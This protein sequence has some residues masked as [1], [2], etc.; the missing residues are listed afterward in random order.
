MESVPVTQPETNPSTVTK[1][2]NPARVQTGKRL[3]EY[4]RR[5]KAQKQ[6]INKQTEQETKPPV[7][8][9]ESKETTS[10]ANSSWRNYV[11]VGAGI[12]VAAAV[13]YLYKAYKPK[14][15]CPR[16][17]EPAKTKPEEIPSRRIVVTDLFEME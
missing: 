4:N 8:L 9:S 5:N 17:K 12:T 11:I 13:G 1:A 14:H 16:K 15:T 3:V 2:K 10:D 7:T 6:N